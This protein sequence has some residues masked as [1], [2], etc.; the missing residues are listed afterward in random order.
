M[1]CC[2]YLRCEFGL[3]VVARQWVPLLTSKDPRPLTQYPTGLLPNPSVPWNS[4]SH[5]P[6]QLM[7]APFLSSCFDVNV[8]VRRHVPFPLCSHR[9]NM[10]NAQGNQITFKCMFSAYVFTATDCQ[11]TLLKQVFF[12]FH[13]WQ[14]SAATDSCLALNHLLLLSCFEELFI[15]IC[16]SG[17]PETYSF[18]WHQL[19]V[20]L[21]SFLL[22]TCHPLKCAII[23]VLPV[24]EM[25]HVTGGH[26]NVLS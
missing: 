25:C 23:L 5:P 18:Y 24:C 13:F 6:S 9:E 1:V 2:S 16:H 11:P 19:A 22:L 3:G 20:S 4:L 26:W 7:L 12:L 8:S 14:R 15:G 21:D 17:V 10:R